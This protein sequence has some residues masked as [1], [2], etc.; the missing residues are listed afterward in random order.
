MKLICR[1][2]KQP[3]PNHTARKCHG[4]ASNPG[5]LCFQPLSYSAFLA[6][7]SVSFVA[8]SYSARTSHVGMPQGSFLVPFSGESTLVMS[9]NISAGNPQIS[10]FSW[11]HSSE[12][13]T[14]ISNCLLDIL[15]F[16]ISGTS[17]S[18][19]VKSVFILSYPST[20]FHILMRDVITHCW[21][22]QKPEFYPRFTLTS[23]T[24]IR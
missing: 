23:L 21:P 1:E 5:G 15:H 3:A 20:V 19:C 9:M 10:L 14:L 2:V 8:F 22:C 11:V 7:A 12:F 13:Q 6:T 16:H 24:S 4:H 17:K 18:T